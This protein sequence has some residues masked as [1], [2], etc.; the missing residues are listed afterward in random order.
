MTTVTQIMQA[1]V[2]PHR[3]SKR[4]PMW[5]ISKMA[6]AAAAAV[7]IAA[8]AAGCTAS[9]DAVRPQNDEIFFPTG[10]AISPDGKLLFVANANSDLKYDSGTVAVLRVAD[11]ETVITAWLGD[12]TQPGAGDCIDDADNDRKADQVCCERE[13]DFTETLGCHADFF[14]RSSGPQGVRI[15]N[16]AT[17][18][19]LQ[20]L[21]DGRLR[22]IV[23][24]RGDPSITWTDWTPGAESSQDRLF[25]NEEKD[26]TD[27]PFHLCDEAHRLAF[28]QNETDRPAISEEPFGVFADTAG[29]FAMVTHL[30]T[31]AV[32]LIDS[33]RDPGGVVQVTDVQMGVFGADPATGLRGSTGVAG[34][35]PGAPGDIVY[36]GSRTEDRIQTFTVGRLANGAPPVLLQGNFFFLDGVGNNANVNSDGSD[37]RG[38]AFSPGGDRLYLV[39]RKPPSLQIFDTSIGPTGVPRNELAGAVDMCRQAST[40]TVVDSGDGER[41][42]VTC[43]QD[44]Q[45]YVVDPRG[46]GRVEDVITVGRGPYSAVAAPGGKRLYVTNF[47]EDTVSVI[48]LTPGSRTRNRVVLRVG[49]PRAL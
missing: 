10:A 38:M 7:A 33:P 35:N 37:T 31:G 21:M 16:F 17:D 32:T 5:P 6:A 30:T 13:A 9:G 15:G 34:R 11:L 44:G 23:P 40:V 41:A 42:Y 45:I 26:E 36:V 39:N 18:I 46:T 19:A 2:G 22:L 29:Q 24:T 25:C 1:T 28:V 20:D 14:L 8:V 3:R 47:L 43:F 27:K 12:G 4:P 49:K 48:D